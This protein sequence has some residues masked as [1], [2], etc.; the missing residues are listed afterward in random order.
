MSYKALLPNFMLLYADFI[1]SKVHYGINDY[2]L[3]YIYMQ[4]ISKWYSL[5]DHTIDSFFVVYPSATNWQ[6]Y[7]DSFWRFFLI[8]LTFRFSLASLVVTLVGAV[9][10]PPLLATVEGLQ[11]EVEE[12]NE[13]GFSTSV[14]KDFTAEEGFPCF[15]ALRL[16]SSLS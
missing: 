5:R 6:G 12:R 15:L 10:F 9:F 14:I 8:S 1:E 13:D 7:L 16:I 11:K 3:Y 2:L 4:C